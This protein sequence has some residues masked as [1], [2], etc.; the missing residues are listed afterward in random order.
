MKF[1]YSQSL[2]YRGKRTKNSLWSVYPLCLGARE[3]EVSITTLTL[4]N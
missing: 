2:H 1:L 4:S 3:Q